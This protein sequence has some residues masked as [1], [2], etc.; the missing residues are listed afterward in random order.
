MPILT[1]DLEFRKTT[2]NLGGAIT[3]AVTDGSDIFDTFTGDETTAG[4]T[5]YACIYF[6]ND[7]GLLASNTRVHL[8]SE[9]AHT[10]VNFTVGL[11][12]SAINGTEQTIADKNTS[13]STVTFIEAADLASAIN[14]GD[15][16]A[17]QHKA[18]WVRGVVDAGTLAKNAYTIATQITTD[19]AE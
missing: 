17:G 9:T 19:S 2:T 13:P 6:Y 11:G 5:E 15:I 3:A 12:T 16:P 8:D 10:G 4:V 1:A 7:S 18:V 14:L